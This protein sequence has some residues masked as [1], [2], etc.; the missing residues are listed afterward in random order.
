MS[1][2]WHVT[3]QLHAGRTSRPP[4]WCQVQAQQLVRTLQLCRC[5]V[6]CGPDGTRHLRWWKNEKFPLLCLTVSWVE[7]M[8]RSAVQLHPAHIIWLWISPLGLINPWAGIS[9]KG[10]WETQSR[11][12]TSI[13][14]YQPGIRQGDTHFCIHTH[15]VCLLLL[16]VPQLDHNHCVQ[17]L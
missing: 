1:A 11:R 5:A 9:A 17:D 8:D 13:S 12:R 3:I 14:T 2:D 4:L 15:R 6:I 16:L 10:S 7:K